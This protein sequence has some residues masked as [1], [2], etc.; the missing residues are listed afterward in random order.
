MEGNAESLC[1]VQH[2]LSPEKLKICQTNN[3]RNGE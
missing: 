1:H 2:Q 3:F